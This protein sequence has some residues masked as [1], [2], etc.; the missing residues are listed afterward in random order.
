MMMF[1]R[2]D[3]Q[4]LV[5]FSTIVNI[6]LALLIVLR[7]I[8]LRRNIRKV[9]GA[10]HGSTYSQ[11]IAMC[12]ESSALIVIFGTLCIV[13]GFLDPNELF[14]PLLLFPHICVGGLEFYDM[15]CTS[16]MLHLGYYYRLSRPSSL[17][18]ALLKVAP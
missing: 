11:V 18:I 6:V 7:L 1:I 9:L 8:H 17:S 16:K 14:V 4:P 3:H 15:W 10:E 5:I 2:I 13:F 12:I